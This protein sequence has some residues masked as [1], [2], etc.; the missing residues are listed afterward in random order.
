[1]AWLLI[2]KHVFLEASCALVSRISVA[3]LTIL[4]TN[5][6]VHGDLHM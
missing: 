1:M 2:K 6:G 5:E 4:P 3:R